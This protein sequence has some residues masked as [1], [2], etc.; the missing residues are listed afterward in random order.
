MHSVREFIN[1]VVHNIGVGPKWTN[2]ET[3]LHAF[4]G[5]RQLRLLDMIYRKSKWF[6][7]V[8][9]SDWHVRARAG[10]IARYSRR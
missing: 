4:T 6:R 10:R 7:Q 1:S 8:S 2:I 3:R 9:E 5:R